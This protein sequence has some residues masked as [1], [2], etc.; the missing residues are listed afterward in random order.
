MFNPPVT[1]KSLL[2]L[3]YFGALTVLFYLFNFTMRTSCTACTSVLLSAV[4]FAQMNS[5]PQ[6]LNTTPYNLIAQAPGGPI[7]YYNGSGDVPSYYETSPDPSP[8]TPIVNRQVFNV[9]TP[10]RLLTEAQL[11]NLHRL[12]Q[13]DLQY[14]K[15]DGCHR[16]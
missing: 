11:L 10:Q 3:Y 2:V 8:I 5:T 6:A 14:H 12:L 15:R 16:Q 13:P 9:L 1:T 7:L 4:A